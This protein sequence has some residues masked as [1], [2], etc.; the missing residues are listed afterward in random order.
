MKRFNEAMRLIKSRQ[1]ERLTDIAYALNYHAQSH[2]IL[3]INAFSGM[4][5]KTVSRKD[6]DLYHEEAS[7]SYVST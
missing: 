5:P 4:T 2:L 6:D 1:Y 7:Y 3:E